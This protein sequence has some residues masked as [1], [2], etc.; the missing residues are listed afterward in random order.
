MDKQ[1][2]I[3]FLKQVHIGDLVRL[4]VVRRTPKVRIDTEVGYVSC[5]NQIS[6]Y[7]QPQHEL[8]RGIWKD[9]PII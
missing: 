8:F 9:N 3:E 7:L 5:L 4:E 1:Q 6:V 2:T